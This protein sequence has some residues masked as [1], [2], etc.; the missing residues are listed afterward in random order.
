MTKSQ[1]ANEVCR[2][3]GSYTGGDVTRLDVKE[4][5]ALWVDLLPKQTPAFMRI[6]FHRALEALGEWDSADED[7]DTVTD[8]LN[9]V[10]E[11]ANIDYHE[12]IV[13]ALNTAAKEMVENLPASSSIIRA[14]HDELQATLSPAPVSAEERR[15]ADLTSAIQDALNCSQVVNIQHK[16][17]YAAEVEDICDGVLSVYVTGQED[18][19]EWLIRDVAGVLEVK[20]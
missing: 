9:R 3:L 1:A 6:S 12:T 20:N 7:E 19:E 15:I 4:S 11:R 8:M 13:I 5:I 10:C 17:G 18:R 2:I 14:L 16:D